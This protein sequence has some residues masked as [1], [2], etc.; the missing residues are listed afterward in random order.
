MIV[1]QAADVRNALPMDET[2]TA[3]KRAFAALSGGR[4]R[5][6]LRIRLEVPPYEGES[7]F[8]P[9]FIDDTEGEK[10]LA[11]KIVS[12]FPRNTQRGVAHHGSHL[13]CTPDFLNLSAS[14]FRMLQPLV[15]FCRMLR[16][17]A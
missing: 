11:V 12:V 16:L 2:T 7:M 8:M 3:M 4:A 5:M 10:A 14:P 9:V 6:P 15:L 17:W 13:H 1:L